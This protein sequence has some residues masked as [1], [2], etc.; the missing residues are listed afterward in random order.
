MEKKQDKSLKSTISSSSKIKDGLPKAKE[1]SKKREKRMGGLL[2]GIYIERNM[3]IIRRKGVRTE[4]K[5]YIN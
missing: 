5:S 4:S 3:I 2:D 1:K